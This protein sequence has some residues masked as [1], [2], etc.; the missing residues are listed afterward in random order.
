MEKKLRHISMFIGFLGIYIFAGCGY[1]EK[2]QQQEQPLR[3]D[4]GQVSDVLQWALYEGADIPL[5]IQEELNQKLMKKGL[6]PVEFVTVTADYPEYWSGDFDYEK[7]V[8]YY[9]E[10]V[11]KSDFDLVT[12]PQAVLGFEYY[13][14]FVEAGALEPMDSYLE[15]HSS[16]Q[17][18]RDAYPEKV[19]KKLNYEG[20]VYGALTSDFKYN[21]YLVSN[22]TIAGQYGI[23]LQELS[24]E[25]CLELAA[26]VGKKEQENGNSTFIPFFYY[27]AE[28]SAEREDSLC[29][30]IN[31]YG[32]EGG[33]EARS[34]LEDE[35]Y[36]QE[37]QRVTRFYQEGI[38]P[39][40]GQLQDKG[41]DEFQEIAKGNFFLMPVYTYS[42]E[43]ALA[44]ARASYG[45]PDYLELQAILCPELNN[46]FMGWGAVTGVAAG[47]TRKE[48]AFAVLAEVYSR[49]ELSDL[50]VYGREGK[51]YHW[52]NGKIVPSEGSAYNVLVNKLSIGNSFL[53]SPDQEESLNRKQEVEMLMEDIPLSKQTGFWLDSVCI[54]DQ[55]MAVNQVY[56]NHMLFF[57]G[58]SENWEQEL[59]QIR[60]EAEEAGIQEILTAWNQQ[61]D[62]WQEGERE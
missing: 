43:S 38:F 46:P 7:L 29:K 33:L 24:R 49:G 10:Q 18:L 51:E 41:T 50:L 55:V 13:P 22:Q 59:E 36:L 44:Q 2:A 42:R 48:E 6:K 31:I 37:V 20:E 5:S 28:K 62:Q 3:A 60:G 16:G 47:S 27:P 39:G 45:V 8:Q 17:E 30:L 15:T 40:S 9:L 54:A 12:L 11:E 23:D 14:I 61:L 35:A 1:Q 56:L 53:L 21:C 57:Q 32:N 52:K 26:E 58:Q 34:I 4:E 19:W 25:N